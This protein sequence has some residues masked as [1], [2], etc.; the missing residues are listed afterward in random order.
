MIRF[1]RLFVRLFAPWRTIR[2]LERENDR[3][4]KA[5]E[6]PLLTGI[7][8]GRERGIEV[9]LKGS[10]PQL[11]AGMFLG[12]LE[13]DGKQA[14]NYFEITF[15]SRKG[16]ILVTVM[17]PDG[18]TPHQLRQQAEAEVRRLKSELLAL[19]RQSQ[20]ESQP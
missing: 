4:S 16:P 20:R 10:G 12:F 14:P 15:G 9:G 18:A 11:L 2:R 3:L 7:E 6:N 8:W 5:L 13:E 19:Q 17:Q 1:K